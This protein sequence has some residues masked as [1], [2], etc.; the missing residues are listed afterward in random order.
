M[1]PVGVNYYPGEWAVGSGKWAVLIVETRLP[2]TPHPPTTLNLG[3]RI[4][5][6]VGPDGTDSFY[7]P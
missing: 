4:V 6:P 1:P 5:F 7:E 3:I 2:P